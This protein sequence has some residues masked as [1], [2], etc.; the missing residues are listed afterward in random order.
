AVTAAKTLGP[1]SSSS[2]N[3]IAARP[4]GS[5]IIGGSAQAKGWLVNIDP[6]LTRPGERRFE[7]YRVSDVGVLASGDIVALASV[8]LSTIGFD[9]SRIA[10]I[11]PTGQVGWDRVLPS[12]G[13]G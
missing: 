7:V 4:D 5:L 11:K 12:T 3:A 6:A 1:R 10:A 9:H 2:F 8:A 13:L